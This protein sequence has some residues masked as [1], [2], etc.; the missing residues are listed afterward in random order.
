MGS[1][2]FPRTAPNSWFSLLYVFL[3]CLVLCNFTAYTFRLLFTRTFELTIWITE[4]FI[5]VTSSYL[6]FFPTNFSGHCHPDLQSQS[7]LISIPSVV[8]FACVTI[9]VPQSEKLLKKNYK[10]N[11][12]Q[13]I[14]SLRNVRLVLSLKCGNNFGQFSNY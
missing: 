9:S 11:S 12:C 13:L 7:P 4:L 5:C 2:T 10:D 14:P 3:F 6:I 8:F 1:R